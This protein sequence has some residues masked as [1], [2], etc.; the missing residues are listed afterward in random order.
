MLL[1]VLLVALSLQ[2]CA[3]TDTITPSSPLRAGDVLTSK[4]GKFTLGFFSPGN[5]TRRYVGI[6]FTKV[7]VLTAV[8]VANRDRPIYGSNGTLSIIE[9][10]HLTLTSGKTVAWSTNISVPV[11]LNK[12]N[13]TS[14][15]LLDSG[16]LVLTADNG[17][18][19]LWQSF[20]HLTDTFLPGM[21]LG[22]D[23][24][25]GLNRY[26]T[27]WRSKDDPRSGKYTF[28][29]DPKGSPQFFLYHGSDLIWRTGPWVGQK[30][31]GVPDMT[32]A[33]IFN[34]S[35]VSNAN[36]V[37]V[38]YN[39][40][41]DSIIT[42]FSVDGLT[43]TV[44]RQTWHENTKHWTK[45]WSAPKELCDQYGECGPFGNC[46]PNGGNQF[47]CTC[48]PGY[49]PKSPRDWYL[50]DGSAGCVRKE[51]RSMCRNGEGFLKLASVK[52]PDT[53][54][55]VVNKSST[56]KQC[57]QEC[58]KNCSCVGYTSADD[59]GG[60]SGCISLYGQLMDT[61]MYPSGGQDVYFRADAVELE[62]YR[63]SKGLFANKKL[64][65][66]LIG[67]VVLIFLLLILFVGYWVHQKI[68]KERQ[69]EAERSLWTK[70]A[71]ESD[72]SSEL[73]FFTRSEIAAATDNFSMANKLGEGGFG[74]V[75]KGRMENGQ[76]IAVKKLAPNSGQGIQEFKNEVRLIAKLQH[77]NLVKMLG[78]CIRGDEK[79]LIYEFMPNKSLDY[80]IFNEEN[81]LSLDWNKRFDIIMGIARGMLYLHQDSRLRIIHRDMKASNVL[82]DKDMV[83]KISDFGMARIFGNEQ[84]QV[85]TTRV[86]GTYG[87][88]AP[89]YAL[90]GLMS[91][92]SDVFSFGVL[93]L[94]II[95]GRKNSGFY[96]DNPSINL[97][98]HVWELWKEGKSSEIVD[99]SLKDADIE[100]L[101]ICIQ[102]G[103]LCVQECADDRPTMSA[104]V[105]MLN[106]KVELPSPNQ[107]AFIHK[108]RQQDADPSSSSAGAYS[109]NE[110]SITSM[111]DGR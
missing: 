24:R 103:L 65:A 81:K 111:I 67:L 96:H 80:F 51:N 23:K 90:E 59:S 63:R 100:E 2:L 102:T 54:K 101:L 42:I 3:S 71:E 6:W 70:D 44:Q 98:G 37:S 15:Q 17:K 77:R 43:G 83:P 34:Y 33:Y 64:E 58:L 85:N 40:L 89:E 30:W 68:K 28:Q 95:T 20:D 75:Y 66:L 32:H 49:K 38:T 106:N 107:P 36:E 69:E 19:L 88:M 91:V 74:S 53:S 72:A 62:R 11:S 46:N 84:V 109:V 99:P 45:F 26:L 8:W 86:V 31:S 94:E 5:T 10:G 73:P 52:L 108:G 50:R 47:Q 87:Y 92:K 16:N 25:T 105:F 104:V 55:A 60:G 56:L 97:V 7:S 27:S 4:A 57:E 93:L 18:T 76:E 14:C 1:R 79:M 78:C 39:L 35:F 21:T 41:S 82:L 12:T 9:G 22:L 29:V 61:R 110:L 48:Y 13:S